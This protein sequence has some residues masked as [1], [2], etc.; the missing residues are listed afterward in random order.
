MS[1]LASAFPDRAFD[2]KLQFT[3]TLEISSSDSPIFI[4]WWLEYDRTL[5]HYCLNI[6]V[7][8]VTFKSDDCRDV[9][10]G[11]IKNQSDRAKRK[12]RHAFVAEPG[13]DLHDCLEPIHGGTEVANLKMNVIQNHRIHSDSQE[14][15]CSA[16]SWG[17]PGWSRS[18]E[19]YTVMQQSLRCN[20]KQVPFGRSCAALTRVAGA[21]DWVISSPVEN[22]AK[23]DAPD[24]ANNLRIFSPPSRH[25]VGPDIRTWQWVIL[26]KNTVNV[27]HEFC[28]VLEFLHLPASRRYLPG[29]V[30]MD[31]RKTVH[32]WAWFAD[33][34]L[35]FA[36]YIT[37]ENRKASRFEQL[38]EP[39][40]RLVEELE[41]V[42][43][44]PVSLITTRFDARSITDRRAW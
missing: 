27:F 31:L 33:I 35:T 36:D 17:I 40:I 41:G 21:G 14:Q 24:T 26:Q 15:S 38:S 37:F 22:R 28:E 43:A 34:A 11:G 18:P 30:P 16:N 29:E 8:I 32:R 13:A 20:H 6:E 1:L 10:V 19:G 4:R 23:N 9:V 2:F 44:A 7:A 5:S 3:G 25:C 42:G 39:T 12:R